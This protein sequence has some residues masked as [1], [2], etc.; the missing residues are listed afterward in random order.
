MCVVSWE[1]PV[2][3]R[4]TLVWDVCLQIWPA[5]ALQPLRTLMAMYLWCRCVV[6]KYCCVTVMMDTLVLYAWAW[7][8][9]PCECLLNYS[10]LHGR[11]LTIPSG[12]EHVVHHSWWLP[13]HLGKPCPIRMHGLQHQPAANNWLLTLLSNVWME[14]I[15]PKSPNEY[16]A[17]LQKSLGSAFEQVRKNFKVKLYRKK[18][19]YDCKVHGQ[20]YEHDVLVWLHS[21]VVPKGQSCKLHHPWTDPIY[22]PTIIHTCMEDYNTC[23]T[24]NL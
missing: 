11:L 13:R 20:H 7:I 3:H 21:S 8:S 10:H 6:H 1:P 19:C 9:R 4:P 2:S 17:A 16:A 5:P 12:P 15:P 22:Y 14:G 24:L 23:T 18:D